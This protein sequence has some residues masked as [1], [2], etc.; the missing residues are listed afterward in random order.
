MLSFLTRR[1]PKPVR[2]RPTCRPTLERLED[3]LTPSI[4]PVSSTTSYPYSAAVE[5]LA[6][7]QGHE[8]SASGAFIDPTHI[9]TA[10]H[11]LYDFTYGLADSVT[12]YAGRNGDTVQPFGAIP[13]AH[14]T[15]HASY[16]SGPYQ[17]QAAYDLGIITLNTPLGNTAGYLGVSPLVPDSYFDNGGTIATLEYPGDTHSGVNQ[18]LATGPATNADVNALY[19]QLQ[20]I[21]IEHGSSGAP[22]YVTDSSGA[23]YIV[24]VVSELSP[25][26]GIASRINNTKFNWIL[27]QVSSTATISATVPT[28]SPPATVG[29]FNPSTAAWYLRDT[30]SPGAPNIEPFDYG[31]PGWFPVVG[32]W[33][34]DGASTIG[35]VDPRATWYLRNS[36]NAGVPDI[37]PFAFGEGNWTPVVGDWDGDGTT[38]IGMFDPATAT[39]YLKNSNGPGAPDIQFRYG[40]PG[41]IPV[42]GDWNG[43]GTTT[44][45]VV[46]PTTETWYLRNSNTPGAPDITPFRYG[47][48]GWLPVAGDWGGDSATGIGVVDPSTETWYLRN[49]TSAGAP[50]IKPFAYG[51]AKWF[52]L[53]GGWNGFSVP[54]QPTNTQRASLAVTDSALFAT[55]ANNPGNSSPALATNPMGTSFQIPSAGGEPTTQDQRPAPSSFTVTA[56]T[57]TTPASPDELAVL[58]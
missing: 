54:Q 10:G 24:G 31:A 52:P 40:S 21:P 18:Y 23:R 30:N 33:N 51:A 7:F 8:I 20:N 2:R 48:P 27:S 29:V 26:E 22:V 1:S 43:D 6:D 15:V 14:W 47:M 56:A 11:A 9:L 44:I 13:G 32:D 16:V 4:Q 39:W 37:T 49:S 42:V 17:G 58:L 19:W 34:G 57:Q 50:D 38:T 12:V 41:W 35:V 36:N 45:G 55:A 46:D 28:P 53:V 25:I 3:R 5:L